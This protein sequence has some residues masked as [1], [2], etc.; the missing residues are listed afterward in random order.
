MGTPNTTAALLG[1][2]AAPGPD[3]ENLRPPTLIT[4]SEGQVQPPSA[5]YVGVNDQL[6]VQAVGHSVGFFTLTLDIRLLLPDGTIQVQQ[7]QV[8]VG[9]P[10]T[11]TNLNFTLAEGF[12]LSVA[13]R[14]Q[15]STM[16]R[17]RVFGLI[18]LIRQ[19]SPVTTLQL[20]LTRGYVSVFSPVAWPAIPPDFPTGRPGSIQNIPVS[21][22]AA[23]ADWTQAVPSLARWRILSVKATLTTSAAAANRCAQLALGVPGSLVYV[24][25]PAVL[26]AASLTYIYNFGAGVTTLLATVGAT[27]LS[28]I[29]AIPVDFWLQNGA[30]IA[31]ATQNIQAADQWSG[32]QIQVEE[33]LDT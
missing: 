14:T 28:V 11:I 18:A 31:S 12:L 13:L 6:S 5:L 7:E 20:E 2:P 8:I 25:V 33:S 29:T 17:G 1:Q 16:K 3:V 9:G 21:N 4:Y 23:G 10:Y 24:A 19:T 15:D 30:S 32:I 27:T 26:Q 22:P